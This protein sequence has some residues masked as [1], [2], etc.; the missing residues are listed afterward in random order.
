VSHLVGSAESGLNARLSS[1]F[2]TYLTRITARVQ[3]RSIAL[4]RAK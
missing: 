3:L 4:S 2:Y 1:L